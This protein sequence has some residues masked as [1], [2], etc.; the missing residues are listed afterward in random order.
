MKLPIKLPFQKKDDSSYY[1]SLLLGDENVHATVFSEK[2]GKIDVVGEHEQHLPTLLEKLSD[3]ELLDILDKTISTAERKLPEGFQTRKTIFGVKENWIE[4]TK[5]KK[6]YLQKLKKVCDNLG[7]TPIGFLVIHEAIAHLLQ[8][9]EGAPVSAILAEVGSNDIAVSILRAGKILETKRVPLNESIAKTIDKTLHVF[10]EYEILPSRLI[11]FSNTTHEKL[12]HELT[13]HQW[14]KSLPFLHV[15]QIKMLPKSFESRAMLFGAATQMGFEVLDIF[16]R[17]TIPN[18]QQIQDANEKESSFSQTEAAEEA[19]FGFMTDADIAHL[20]QAPRTAI[21]EIEKEKETAVETYNDDFFSSEHEATSP[22]HAHTSHTTSSWKTKVMHIGTTIKKQ[23]ASIGSSL[24]L[25]KLS[26][27][28]PVLAQ[29]KGLIFIPPVILGVLLL[30]VLLYI[31]TVKATVMVYIDPK[32]MEKEQNITFSTNQSSDSTQNLI[33]AESVDITQE[34]SVSTTT[35]GKKEIGEKAKGS[36]TLYSRISQSKTFSSGTII[37]GPNGLKFSLDKD[38]T[39]AS[40]SG[41]ASA[42]PATANVAVTAAAIGKESNL[43]SGSKFTITGFNEG[44]V[45]AKNG[46]AFSGGS[47]KDITIV[48]KA[49]T[50]KLLDELPKKLTD[51]AKEALAGKVNGTK[52]LLPVF[53]QTGVEKKTFDKDVGEE[54]TSVTLNGSVSFVSAAY[55]KK[56]LSAYA[57]TQLSEDNTQLTPAKESITYSLTDVSDKDGDISAKMHIKGYLLPKIEK[58]SVQETIAGNSFPDATRTLTALPQV[59]R[60]EIQLSPPLPFLPA[61]LPRLSNNITIEVKTNE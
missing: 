44:D 38:V 60:V 11:V 33:A 57:L 13:S 31:F 12:S 6:D 58:E 42:S 59:K 3:D 40:S 35:T 19:M 32:T 34:G 39:V 17:P 37:T 29:R 2:N 46:D 50:A 48:A 4:D 7:L 22:T 54:A 47:K 52:E 45:V 24:H 16:D 36:V 23:F 14:S 43:P 56:E 28:F 55:D 41:D 18:D 1:L 26:H 27:R 20:E 9:E 49:D 53:L 21:S 61:F 8:K 15:P 10:T 30:I 51:K 25:E 5:I